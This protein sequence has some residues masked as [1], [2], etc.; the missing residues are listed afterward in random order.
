MNT[1]LTLSIDNDVI[2][3]AKRYAK[4]T[5]RSLSDLI[6]NYLKNIT[7]SDKDDFKISPRVKNLMG[8]FN[9]P[10]DFDYKT[11][12]TEVLSEKYTK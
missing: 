8:A 7:S 4:N 3:K 2:T 9:V 1:K 10:E 12:L 6:E 11:E 5:G